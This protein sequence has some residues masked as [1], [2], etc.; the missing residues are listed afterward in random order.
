M[1]SVSSS[2]IDV[3]FTE[4][5]V[6]TL[7]LYFKGSACRPCNVR[8]NQTP[9]CVHNNCSHATV[10]TGTSGASPEP[11]ARREAACVRSESKVRLESHVPEAPDASKQKFNSLSAV[12]FGFY[13][14]HAVL[15]TSITDATSHNRYFTSPKSRCRGSI[16]TA[17]SNFALRRSHHATRTS[18]PVLTQY[19]SSS[20]S[21]EDIV[22]SGDLHNHNYAPSEL[23]VNRTHSARCDFPLTGSSNTLSSRPNNNRGSRQVSL[24]VS[25]RKY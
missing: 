4:R 13:F 6:H 11:G 16:A 5:P 15:E 12:V 3:T 20:T 23:L 8:P 9:K 18:M 24:D 1:I 19:E 7:I 22:L 21:P 2:L 14:G 25:D 10:P 17:A